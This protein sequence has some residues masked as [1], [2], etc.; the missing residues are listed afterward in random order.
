M[1][2]LFRSRAKAVRYVLGAVLMLVAVS[3]VVTL[4][5][6]FGSGGGDRN[7]QIVAEVGKEVLSAHDVQVRVQNIL[8]GGEVPSSMLAIY[9]PQIVDEEITTR[10]VV[11]EAKRLGLAV[12]EAD[13]ARAIRSFAPML[14]QGG[15]FVGREAYGAYLAQMNFTIP[16][17]EKNVASEM[18]LTQMKNLVGEGVVVTRDEV[19][20][21]YKLKNEMAKIEYA[22]VDPAKYR[23][24][25]TVSA[26]EIQKYFL[27]NRASFRM[28]EQ[29][30]F[31]MLVVEEEKV[32]ATI[33]IPEADLRRDYE[34]NKDNFRTPERVKVRHILLKTTDKPQNEI[35]KI[36]AKI[37][38]LL[39]QIK[40]GADFAAL[41]K[42]YSEDTG[43]AV[44]GGDLG[45]V[46]RGQTVPNFEKMAFSLKPKQISGIV[47]TEYGFHIMQV[48]EKQD[49]R[50]KSFEEAKED[51]AKERK[52]QLVFD[53]MQTLSDEMR[54][55][56]V[57]SPRDAEQ[58]A[59]KLNVTFA[60][61][62][63]AGLG[64]P[65]PIIGVS[66]ELDDSIFSLPKGDVTPVVQAPGNKLA[67]AV[68]S[69]IMPARPA[70]LAEVEDTVRTRLVDQKV[71]QI[72]EQKARELRDKA[73]ALG[74]NL[75]QA[76]QDMGVV[77][78]TVPEFNRGGAVEGLGSGAQVM[79]AFTKPI[80]SVFG[81]IMI[82]DMR[83]VCKVVG[84][85]PP[86]PAQL[87]AERE[88]L[89]AQIKRNKAMERYM[90]FADGL[91]AELV[92]QGKI[93]I[94]QKV[95]DRIVATYRSS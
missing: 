69:D 18:L 33:N 24:Q 21:A 54:A 75:K 37:E 45:W 31:Q 73:M 53:R 89:I 83:F 70:E 10:A 68:V 91:R 25:V 65:L 35:P 55:E 57:K 95:I 17:F 81:P 78:K 82:G 56:L 86:D 64:D 36:R 46:T 48:M 20:R 52:K 92:R 80:G 38:D 77:W 43:S 2:D 88:M 63:K 87:A 16:E 1:F 6:G 34:A 11:Y 49:A 23:P 7:D 84:R 74:G 67:V 59:R 27:E 42:K 8:R 4:I 32:A 62:P 58:I 28:K 50:L 85:T 44:K 72:V 39:K 5:P 76:A 12:S 41:A 22:T 61:V 19:E 71:R 30:A 29:R 14:Y 3:M 94:H 79:D 9:V 26:G 47:Q 90:L 15:K 93:K 13:V 66:K 51:L 40:G 60:N